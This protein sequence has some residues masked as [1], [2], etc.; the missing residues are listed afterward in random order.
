VQEAARIK[1][2]M[3]RTARRALKKQIFRIER[4]GMIFVSRRRTPDFRLEPWQNMAGEP[5]LRRWTE[6]PRAG[7][8]TP[9]LADHG[10][11]ILW[12]PSP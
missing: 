10:K 7:A 9:P 6:H 4:V 12:F 2:N 11:A 5:T 3:L 1:K 8:S